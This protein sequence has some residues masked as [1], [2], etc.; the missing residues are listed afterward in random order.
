M[1]TIKI[2]LKEIAISLVAAYILLT[3]KKLLII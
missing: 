2:W 3:F 1:K